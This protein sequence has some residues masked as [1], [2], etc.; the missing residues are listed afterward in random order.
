MRGETDVE[1]VTP[2]ATEMLCYVY[3]PK[4]TM[5]CTLTRHFIQSTNH[6]AGHTD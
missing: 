1:G 5:Q 6:V 3:T 2:D 4:N